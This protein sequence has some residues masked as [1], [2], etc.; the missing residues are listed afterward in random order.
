MEAHQTPGKLTTACFGRVAARETS[1]SESAIA[2]FVQ[3]AGWTCMLT[4]LHKPSFCAMSRN[5]RRSPELE[6]Q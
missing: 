4:M 5:T 3:S 6:H 1:H 2:R